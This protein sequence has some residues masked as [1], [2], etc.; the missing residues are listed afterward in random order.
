M[1]ETDA[2]VELR[3]ASQAFLNQEGQ[4]LN[5]G[6]SGSWRGNHGI[7]P[8]FIAPSRRDFLAL[9]VLRKRSVSQQLSRS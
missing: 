4:L 7:A 2:G 8:A 3:I 6:V 5:H 1:N 9:A